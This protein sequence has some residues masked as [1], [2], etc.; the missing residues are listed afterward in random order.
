V[1][2]WKGK[3]PKKFTWVNPYGD[4]NL[5]YWETLHWVQLVPGGK[6]FY[7]EQ[8]FAYYQGYLRTFPDGRTIYAEAWIAVGTP[9]GYAEANP[10]QPVCGCTVSWWWPL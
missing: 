8:G 1:Y 2:V 6:R 3:F 9:Y 7:S 10:A 4:W 5:E